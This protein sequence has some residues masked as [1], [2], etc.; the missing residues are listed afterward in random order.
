MAFHF[1]TSFAIT[2]L[3]SILQYIEDFFYSQSIVRILFIRN[4][5][6]TPIFTVCFRHSWLIF[7][8]LQSIFYSAITKNISPGN[9]E[10]NL[11][12]G[13]RKVLFCFRRANINR[14]RISA[15]ADNTYEPNRMR[16]MWIA[17]VIKLRYIRLIG[18]IELIAGLWIFSNSYQS[19]SFSPATNIHLYIYMY[20]H[21]YIYTPYSIYI[22]H[23][24]LC[25]CGHCAF[26]VNTT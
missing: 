1:H 11:R 9:G 4:G 3:F 17:F 21:T 19:L 24:R 5:S 6:R 12:S 2:I 8:L 15:V 18:I 7:S 26:K 22:S 14:G 25:A 10:K 23:I 13:E 20:I 16:V